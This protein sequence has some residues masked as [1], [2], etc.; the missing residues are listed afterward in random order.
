MAKFA[1]MLDYDMLASTNY[2]PFVYV[3]NP[4]I[5]CPCPPAADE[6]ILGGLHNDYLKQKLN[7]DS[8]LYPVDNRSD[9]AGFREPHRPGDRPLH[10][11]GDAQDGCAGRHSTAARPRSRPTRATTSGATRCST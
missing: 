8:T 6:A 7:M 2:I 3:P 10:R 5:A 9:Y 11:R 4:S 1:G